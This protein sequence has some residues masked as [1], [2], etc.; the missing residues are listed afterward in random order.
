MRSKILFVFEMVVVAAIFYLDWIG[1]LPVSKTP[2]LFLLGWISLRMRGLRWK[3]VGLN[4]EQPFAKVVVL[5]VLV[6]IAM[7]ALELFA[8]QPLLTKLLNKG[9]DLH[10]VAAIVGNWKLLIIGIV[11]AWTLAAFGEETVWRGY[12][13][14]RFADILG[15]STTGWIISAILISLLFGLAHFPQGTTGVIENVIDGAILAALYF[16][17]GRN[18]WAPIVAHGIQDTV[19]VVLI[20]SGHYPGLSESGVAFLQH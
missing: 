15:R 18:L 7:E 1:K 10:E 19:D 16:A 9:P 13:L 2:Y 12:L 3:N 20:Y 5:G 4:R 11:L 8:T 6:G 14:N 17:T